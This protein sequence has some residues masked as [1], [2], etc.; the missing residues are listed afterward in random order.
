MASLYHFTIQTK[1][2][3]ITYISLPD[4]NN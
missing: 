3:T 2:K 1:H 4:A